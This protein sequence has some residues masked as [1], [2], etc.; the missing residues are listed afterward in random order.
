LS[1]T[2]SF[3]LGYFLAVALGAPLGDLIESMFKRQ[4]GRKDAGSILPGFGGILDR[5]DSLLIVL[6]LAAV[7]G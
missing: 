5:V 3:S 2:N 4:A 6:P 1:I 7:L